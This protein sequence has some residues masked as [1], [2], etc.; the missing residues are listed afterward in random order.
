MPTKI[1][2]EVNIEAYAHHNTHPINM[3]LRDYNDFV[4][5]VL[6]KGSREDKPKNPDA[7]SIIKLARRLN[8]QHIINKEQHLLADHLRQRDTYMAMR[9]GLL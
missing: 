4:K 2:I 3:L 1:K 8:L 7:K 6:R 9:E 5:L